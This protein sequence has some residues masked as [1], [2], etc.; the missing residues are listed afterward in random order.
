MYRLAEERT[1]PAELR[2][3]EQGHMRTKM[4]RRES[5]FRRGNR[6][7]R[8]GP[9]EERGE[10]NDKAEPGNGTK[11]PGRMEGGAEMTA[12]GRAWKGKN[13]E[14]LVGLWKSVWERWERRGETRWKGSGN[15]NI[16]EESKHTFS[17]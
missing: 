10:D 6:S 14:H 9:V 17:E 11:G 3:G 5:C 7:F 2:G 12:K 8:Y 15:G 13:R 1:G 16:E 4:R